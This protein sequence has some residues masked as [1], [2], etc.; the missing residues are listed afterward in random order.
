MKEDKTPFVKLGPHQVCPSGTE[1]KTLKRCKEAAEWTDSLGL[2]PKRD[3]IS[4]TWT[5]VPYQCSAQV[6]K[7][8]TI[9]YSTNSQTDNK[10]FTS[11]EFVMICEKGL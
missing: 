9:H 2:H 4:G 6:G 7:D 8:D 3:I 10:R 1:I 5:G 11:G